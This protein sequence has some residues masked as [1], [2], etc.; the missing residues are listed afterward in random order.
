MGSISHAAERK[1]FE[2]AL[3][4]LMKKA[5]KNR[6]EGYVEIINMIERY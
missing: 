2:V 1:A 4:S 6:S 5:E 3:D